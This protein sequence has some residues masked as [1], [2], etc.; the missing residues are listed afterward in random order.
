[1]LAAITVVVDASCIIQ[2]FH[3]GPKATQFNANPE[4]W[5]RFWTLLANR[6]GK[7]SLAVVEIKSHLTDL[8]KLCGV[9]DFRHILANE[10]ADQ[11]ATVAEGRSRDPALPDEG[12]L[13]EP[14]EPVSGRV[15][16]EEGA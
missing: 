6:G 8:E 9:A 11:L 5:D 3:R 15:R 4:L 10:A 2:G 12:I 1:M 16:P 14:N 13:R 7:K